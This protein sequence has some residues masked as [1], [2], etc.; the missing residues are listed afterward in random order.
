MLPSVNHWIPDATVKR[1]G[2]GEERMTAAIPPVRRPVVP[3]RRSADE[4]DN[5]FHS[6]WEADE[7]ELEHISRHWLETLHFTTRIEIWILH[8]V[9]GS[10]EPDNLKASTN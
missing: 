5:V 6:F 2:V 8:I 4:N 7:D 10:L 9:V 1:A 3:G